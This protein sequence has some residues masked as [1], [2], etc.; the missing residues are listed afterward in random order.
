[1]SYFK[2]LRHF[3][4]F[5]YR[6]KTHDKRIV[7]YAEHEGY[8]VCF[9]GIIREL[10]QTHRTPISYVTSD[11][12]DPLLTESPDGV[13]VFYLKS[14][15]PYFMLLVKCRVFVMT[16]PDLHQFQFKRSMNPLHYVYV[17]HS[18]VST[19]MMYR[20]GAFDHYDSIL[21]IGPHHRNEIRAYEAQNG[22]QA[23]ELVKAGYYRL[24]RIHEQ[25]NHRT[26]DDSEPR[27]VLIAPSWGKANLLES[28]GRE[29]V[30]LL[31][32]QGYRVI[33][34]PHPETV[35]RDPDL[36]ARLESAFARQSRF[37]LERS[38][39]TDDS[40][41]AADV[42]LCDLSGVALEYAFGT[43]RPVLFFDVAPKVHNDEYFTLGL[44][45]VEME[46]RGQLG[47]VIAVDELG[48]V[49]A[50]IKRLINQREQYRSRLAQLRAEYVF[51]LG[52][53][54]WI[55]AAHIMRVTG[56]AEESVE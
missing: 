50:A 5:F 52:S 3:F 23:K 24:E 35:R 18:M 8:Y 48:T 11:V 45:P 38:V 15:L 37:Q 16:L 1:V 36:I 46:L 43:E 49:P 4:R 33:V 54:S 21:C 19:H 55:G 34:R 2:E 40:L 31:L 28:C 39:S 44:R 17:F 26:S 9:E 6:T 22:L 14:L 42:L 47:E 29:L 32:E 12:D 51:D 20:A 53:S 27:T 25:A 30:G 41:L 56:E 10:I 7:F 13:H